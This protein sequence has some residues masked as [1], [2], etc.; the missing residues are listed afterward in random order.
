VHASVD[1]VIPT[2]NNVDELRRCLASILP[3]MPIGRVLVCVDGSTDGTLEFLA[4]TDLPFPL[5]V[6]EHQ[7]RQNHGRSATR[8]LA[9]PHL[10]AEHVLLLDADMRLEPDTANRHLDLLERETTAVSVGDVEYLNARENIW[11]R[12]IATRGRN[13]ARPGTEI[14]PLDLNTQNVAL[15]R[16]SLVEVG[17]FDVSLTGYGGEDTELGLRLAERG[18]GF[19][20][21]AAARV[22][23]VEHKTVGEGLSE[24]RTYARTNLHTTRTRHPGGPAP[25]WIDRFDS[26]TL[27]NRA[28]R[29]LLNPLTDR[30]VDLAL[31]RMPFPVQRR[32][33]DYKV[34]RA[35]FSGYAEGATGSETSPAR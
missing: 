26:P 11:A 25:F 23:T 33:L 8:N 13:K 24:L 1:I 6:L 22:T 7:D 15:R 3:R 20:F 30:I 31:P 35:V 34:I 9:L 28:L 17:G 10:S 14:R 32:L 19:V 21:N 5:T 18:I 27:V 29:T 2:F 16:R 12:Y 4:S